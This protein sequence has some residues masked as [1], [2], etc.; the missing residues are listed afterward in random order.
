M[1]FTIGE[2]A[3][4]IRVLL[5]TLRG[6]HRPPRSSMI[7][8]AIVAT[9]IAG[10]VPDLVHQTADLV[11]PAERAFGF[12]S[13]A[14]MIAFVLW[15]VREALLRYEVT[16]DGIT[17]TGPFGL[18]SWTVA[19][20]EIHQIALEI[21]RGWVL[22]VTTTSSKKRPVPL[23]GSLRQALAKLYPELSPFEPTARDIQRWK[24]LGA[25]LSILVVGLTLLLWWLARRGLISW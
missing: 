15:M 10:V 3:A 17:K 1:K 24:M 2:S 8:Y 25:I 7:T 14:G 20:G 11:D 6:V 4:D 16:D 18:L 9:V 21:D 12:A 13:V 19:R 5:E 23:E 22:A